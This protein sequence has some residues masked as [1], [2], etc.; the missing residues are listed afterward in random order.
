M[1]RRL[2]CAS[3]SKG[4]VAGHQM[5][6]EASCKG[7]PA[8]WARYAIGQA[9]PPLPSQRVMRINDEWIP[10]PITEFEC[11]QCGEAIK[12]GDRA[13]AETIWQDDQAEPAPWEAEYL[14]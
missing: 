8:E 10:L 2:L 14:T 13:C 11:D 3:C 9:R 6:F 5:I 4:K 1:S 12:S 7:E